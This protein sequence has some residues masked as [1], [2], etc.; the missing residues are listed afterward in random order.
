MSKLKVA[1]AG[2][3]EFASEALRAILEVDAK[4]YERAFSITLA[5][6]SGYGVHRQMVAEMVN[7]HAR[8]DLGIF[9]ARG[10][11]RDKIDLIEYGYPVP[12]Y[13]YPTAPEQ[14]LIL[15]ITRQESN[16]NPAAVSFA[17][18]LAVGEGRRG[19]GEKS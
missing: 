5:E 14:A 19:K 6:S 17:G 1:F 13:A 2:T 12:P 11:A 4:A 7:R 8:P 10:A 9:I 3:P 18:A 16:F 15:A